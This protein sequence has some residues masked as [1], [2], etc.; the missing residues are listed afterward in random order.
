MAEECGLPS[1]TVESVKPEDGSICP[2]FVKSLTSGW[3]MTDRGARTE[4]KRQDK[5]QIVSDCEEKI[6]HEQG[7]LSCS[8]TDADISYRI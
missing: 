2:T 8:R 7:T 4:V 5:R 3:K 1:K 6:G